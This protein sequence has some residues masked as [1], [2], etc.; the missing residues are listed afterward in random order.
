MENTKN[1][2]EKITQDEVLMALAKVEW[3]ETGAKRRI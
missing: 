2:Q 1:K 3:M